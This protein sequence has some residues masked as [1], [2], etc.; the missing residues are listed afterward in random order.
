MALNGLP[1]PKFRR[2]ELWVCLCPRLGAPLGIDRNS[3]LHCV[4]TLILE[5]KLN[6]T[7]TFKGFTPRCAVALLRQEVDPSCNHLTLGLRIVDYE[8]HGFIASLA[9]R[10]DD[11]F[12]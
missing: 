5:L 12:Q 3:A 8:A 4:A 6:E 7:P 10:M 1:V 9:L 2:A 11:S